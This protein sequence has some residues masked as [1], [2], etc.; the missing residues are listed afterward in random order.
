M[1]IYPSLI[2][3]AN[4]NVTNDPVGAKNNSMEIYPSLTDKAATPTEIS[5]NDTDEPT[6][7]KEAADIAG[8]PL[9]AQDLEDTI[10]V[11]D[12]PNETKAGDDSDVL[13]DVSVSIAVF[14][15]TTT[16]IFL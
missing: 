15:F 16:S 3:T 8:Q 13:E 10:I 9:G 2:D 6:T 1:E 7:T 14:L 12:N 11:A 5:K 4:T